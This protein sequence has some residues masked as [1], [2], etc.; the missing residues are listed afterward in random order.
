MTAVLATSSFIGTWDVTG[1]QE[2]TYTPTEVQPITATSTQT[3]PHDEEYLAYYREYTPEELEV[4]VEIL[5]VFPDAPIMIQVADCESELK[6]EADRAQLG[7]DVGV[8]QINQVH[9]PEMAM[10]G[11]DRR[12]LRDNIAFA[13]ILYDRAGTQPWYM[14]E[15]CWGRHLA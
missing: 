11:L 6:P 2:P 7:V 10:L 14:S 5:K 15:Y 4:V 13:R 12:V 3:Q 1:Q 8:F 9:L